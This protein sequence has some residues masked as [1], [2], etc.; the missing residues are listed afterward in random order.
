MNKIQRLTPAGV[1][2]IQKREACV[3]EIYVACFLVWKNWKI[4]IFGIYLRERA[5]HI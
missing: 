5:R 4:I 2:T 1:G 3:K